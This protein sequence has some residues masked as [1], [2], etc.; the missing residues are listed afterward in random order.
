MNFPVPED[1]RLKIEEREKRNKY[2]DLARD[3]KKTWEYEDDGDT[4][5]NWCV[6]NNH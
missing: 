3:V 6:Q 1:Q 5:F 2:L 4:N